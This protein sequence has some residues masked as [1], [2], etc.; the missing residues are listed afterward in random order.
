MDKAGI[1]TQSEGRE[2]LSKARWIWPEGYMYLYNHFAQFRHDFEL[3]K[4]LKG[5]PAQALFHITADKGY[6]LY[7]NGK[8][9][10]RGP[11]RGYQSHWPFDT[12]D[13]RSYLQEGHNWISVEAYNPGI[14]T[15]VYLHYTKA[16]MICAADWGKVKIS[17]NLND[18]QMR[19]SPAH[20]I[21]TARLSMQLDFQEHY[22]A[23]A[24]DRKWITSAKAPKGWEPKIFKFG[25]SINNFPFGQPPYDDVEERQIPLL[26]EDLL[27]P[28]AV[29]GQGIGKNASGYESCKNVSW[30][31]LDHELESV[32]KWADGSG[33]KSSKTSKGL[34]VIIP[35][36]ANDSFN[37]VTVDLGQIIP[38][39]LELEVKGA[40]GSEIID[41]QYHQCLR[42][43][44]PEYI[45]PGQ[46][47][48]AAFASRYRP[49]KGSSSHEFFHV[50]GIRHITVVARDLKKPLTINLRWRRAIYPFTMEGGFECSD[51]VLNQIHDACRV[52]QQAC[53][54]DAYVDTPWREQAQWWGDARVQ[55]RNTFYLDGDARL[56]ARGI[57]SIA[58]QRAPQGLTYGHAPT[59]SGWC[60]LPDFALTWIMTIWDYYWQ[61]GEIDI[62]HEQRARID[63]ILEYFESPAAMGKDG[64]LIYDRRFWLFEDWATLPKEHIPTF[65][66]LWYIY[67]VEYYAKMLKA[68]GDNKAY[69]KWSDKISKRRKLVES[70]LL[71][72]KAGLFF[73]GYND[74]GK[75]LNPPSVHDQV[76]AVMTGL[77][78]KSEEKMM[79]KKLVPF[80]KGKKVTGAVPSAFWSTYLF[81]CLGQKGYGEEVIDYIK[82]MWT[83]MLTTGTTWEGYDWG[84]GA[85]T[86]CSHAWSAHPCYHMVNII[87]GINQTAPAWKEISWSP[88]F[89]KGMSHASAIIPTP[90][91]K[92]IAG[93][94][95]EDGKKVLNITI[96][97]GVKV[98]C[99]LAGLPKTINKT[100]KHEFIIK[101]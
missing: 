8:H 35:P 57:R 13:L 17:S 68:A 5:I 89:I 20:E 61:T 97:K 66:N 98:S 28:E 74:K 16:G 12:V 51:E 42:K 91:G 75:K 26:R 15:F 90:Q 76:L 95:I 99:E 48:H 18:W 22:N 3:P 92:I 64:L 34:Q 38:G 87:A 49:A 80:I 101:G 69:R 73:A 71:D 88:V 60:I 93:W 9:V 2:L 81:E 29:T 50:V 44:Y 31:W 19:R 67:T 77:N 59:C 56:L 1:L 10:C 14:S 27:I 96:P 43:G 7:V 94:K 63:E 86:T 65:L 55:A 84:E 82:K 47:C 21:Q 4:G 24:D 6:R 23:A 39:T 78:S 85:N 100:G 11:A 70:K 72:K 36:A 40:S 45:Q 41:L 83:P 53:S 33:I 52:T 46:A 54:L 37:A 62:F 25:Q 79:N 58:G 30:F 32:K